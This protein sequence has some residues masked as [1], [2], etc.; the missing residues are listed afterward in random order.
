MKFSSGEACL[1]AFLCL[2]LLA[3]CTHKTNCR[4]SASGALPSG[5]Q[6]AG[7]S[8]TSVPGFINDSAVADIDKSFP[9]SQAIQR[10]YVVM[11]SDLADSSGTSSVYN[12]KRLDE[13][14]KNVKA[15]K[16]DKV[17]ILKY[18]KQNG[19]EI[20]N[21]FFEEEYDGSIL[22][23]RGYDPYNGMTSTGRTVYDHIA[24]IT[25]PD[26]NVRYTACRKQDADED[27]FLLISYAAGS[28]K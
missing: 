8:S 1:T 22:T 6:S 4:A 16:K 17:R 10:N 23:D 2:L 14:I 27:G 15:G 7:L 24:K 20:L 28:A 12:S 11:I 18:A 3:G 19:S 9:S 21:K 13:F 5:G 25:Y 26:G